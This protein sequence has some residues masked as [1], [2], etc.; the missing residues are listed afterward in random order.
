VYCQANLY[1]TMPLEEIELSL[2][3]PPYSAPEAVAQWTAESDRRIDEF[4]HSE[5]NRK[6]PKYL[7][8]DPELLH[9][10]LQSITED[11]LPLGRVFCE[12]GSGFGVG[13]GIAALLGYEAWGIE[14]EDELVG[15]AE[16]LADDMGVDANFLA[17]SY[18]PEGYE[19]AEGVGGEI[20]IRD[21]VFSHPDDTAGRV[22][23]IGYE[24]MDRE[25]SEVDVFYVYPWPY[26][27]EFMHQLFDALAVEGAILITY[28][29]SG[30]ISV[31]RK[32]ADE[33]DNTDEDDAFDDY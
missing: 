18:L 13:T 25:L 5:R 17:T 22:G 7:P 11:D 26:Q 8:S 31:W 3:T 33:D 23:E 24:G 1:V 30:E 28:L 32:I 16:K 29:G 2:P 15:I 20:L 4:F 19:S 21:A 12:W 6:L 9:A 14:L 10:V 27:Q